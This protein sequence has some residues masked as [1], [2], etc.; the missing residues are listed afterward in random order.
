[1]RSIWSYTTVAGLCWAMAVSPLMAQ[2]ITGGAQPPNKNTPGKDQPPGKEGATNPAATDTKKDGDADKDPLVDEAAKL[3][4]DKKEDEAYKK[5]QEAVAKND[6]LPPARLMMHRMYLS[7]GRAVDARRTLEQAAVENPDHPDIYITLAMQ[8]LQQARLT[9]A[10]LQF[11]RAL[12]TIQDTKRW[13]ESQRKSVMLACHSGLAQTAEARQQ[14]DVARKNY[15]IVLGLDFPKNQLAGFRNA[16]GRMMFM[17]DKKEDALKDLQQSYADEPEGDPAGVAM[18]KLYTN[19]AMQEKD[20]PKQKELVA[21]AKEWFEYALK[22]DPK[23][24]KSHI[25]YAIW[26]FDM[27]YLD[28]SFYQ[29]SEEELKESIKLDPKKF[30]NR[31]LRGLMYRWTGNYEAAEQEFEAAWKEGLDKPDNFFAQNQLVFALVEQKGNPSKMQ[32]AVQLATENVQKHGQRYPESSTTYGY[33]MFKNNR[34]DDAEKALQVTFQSGQ[35]NADALYYLS[36]VY[37]YRGKLT[38]AAEALKLAC[39]QPGRFMYRK[40]ATMDLEQLS[41]NKTKP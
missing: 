13:N 22:S 17:L 40:E 20:L 26:L 18:A 29:L 30:D 19:K 36:Q 1:M 6:K 4:Q 35:F 24:Y 28:K 14:W 33:V 3:F 7:A 11:E 34:L 16:H 32:R 8:A 9:D 27:A 15:E 23:S 39:A 21:K 25:G 38:E 37:R 12:L 5:L 31:I 41:G 10:W 2:P